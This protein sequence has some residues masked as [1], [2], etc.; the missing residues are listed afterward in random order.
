MKL[1]SRNVAISGIA[2]YSEILRTRE[3]AIHQFADVQRSQK[4]LPGHIPV[5]FS[6]FSHAFGGSSSWGM[7]PGQVFDGGHGFTGTTTVEQAVIDFERFSTV[8]QHHSTPANHLGKVLPE[9]VFDGFA[10]KVCLFDLD[11]AHATA[12]PQHKVESRVIHFRIEHLKVQV[13]ASSPQLLPYGSDQ[14][15]GQDVLNMTGSQGECLG[16]SVFHLKG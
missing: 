5:V 1:P 4:A 3:Q 10:S 9:R 2:I 11:V 7:R 15:M 16:V 12:A 13:W 14:G 6:Y 8:D